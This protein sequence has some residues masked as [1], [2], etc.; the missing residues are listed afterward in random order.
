MKWLNYENVKAN[1][2][3]QTELKEKLGIPEYILKVFINRGITSLKDAEEIFK[4]DEAP[5][6]DPFLFEN[7]QK[8]VDRIA[9]AMKENEKIMIYGDYDVDGV[10]SIAILYLFIKKFL[11]YENVNFYIPHR[12]EEG[13]GLN[14]E[15]LKGIKEEGY[16]LIITVDCGISALNEVK[17]CNENEMDI[18]I[19]DHHIAE[20]ETPGAWAV[21]NSKVSKT[22]PD[23]ELS[24]VG[25]AYKL[26]CAIAKDKTL[27]IKD[28]FLDFVALGTVADIVPLT[29]ENRI[30]V[31]RGLKKIKNTVNLGLKALK[32]VA[33]IKKDADISTYHLGFILGP[34]INAAGRLEHAKKAVELFISDDADKVMEIAQALNEANNE[35]KELMKKTETEAIEK[36]KGKFNPAEDFVIVLY[37]E[38]WH[39]GI[40]GLV[41]S[42]IVSKFNR[43]TFILTKEEENGQVH[44]SA[45]SL[46][47]VNIYEALQA[48]A[49]ELLRYGGHKLA[50]GVTL[51][52]A[53]IPNFTKQLNE[54]LKKTTTIADFE[55]ALYIDSE[56][57]N[58]AILLRDI[59]T[60]EK[61]EP[62]GPGNPKPL[63][64]M[65]GV[66]VKD[67]K[68]FKG[69]TMKFYAKHRDKTYNF[70]TFGVQDEMKEKV[71]PGE[72]LDVVFTPSINVWNDEENII[73]EVKDI[74]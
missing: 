18:I 27:D 29:Y 72:I 37:D 64:S 23:K 8:A 58:E 69:N 40:V 63:F 22:Y 71:K 47:N 51:L 65:K 68:F 5:L 36:L 52:E 50:A 74:K 1:E 54:Y 19:T 35:R 26:I 33:G 32:E 44:G 9:R 4:I 31:R 7:M 67:V 41:A 11:K 20:T 48:V 61:L 45:R 55:Q 16:K 62:W 43:P 24:G 10:T 66:D 3:T 2:K 25:T 59:R 39:A 28:Y 6:H 46:Q 21:I 42:K 30:L 60:L 13:Y 49:A 34:R 53:N 57:T 70:I 56:I 14:I 38:T 73:L 17:F 15:A 12:R